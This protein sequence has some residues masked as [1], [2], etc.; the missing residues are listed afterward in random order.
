MNLVPTDYFYDSADSLRLYCGLYS[1]RLS[2]LHDV[3]TADLRGRGRSAWDPD[4]SHYQLTTYV[5]D[6]FALLRACR[7]KR[8]VVVGTSLGGSRAL[9]RKAPLLKPR[10]RC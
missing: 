6:A 3:L 7:V 2:E 9:I 1:A 5:K 8:V 10:G 4:L